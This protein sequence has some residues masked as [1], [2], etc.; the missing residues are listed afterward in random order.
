MNYM[1]PDA[2]RRIMEVLPDGLYSAEEAASYYGKSIHTLRKWRRDGF[3]PKAFRLG[4]SVKY[5]GADLVAFKEECR[6]A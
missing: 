2:A 1:A 3:G 4:G 6:M 5:Q